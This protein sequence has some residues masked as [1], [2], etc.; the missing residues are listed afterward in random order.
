MG[1]RDVN[2]TLKT[3]IPD[4][5]MEIPMSNFRGKAIAIDASLYMFKSKSS[6]LK[7][8]LSITKDPLKAL[9]SK[10]LIESM[11]K[12]FYGFTYKICNFGITPVW[13]FDGKTH[14]AKLA[15]D[16]RK[17]IKTNKK[18][19]L[20]EERVRLEAMD[21]LER[22]VEID[23]FIKGVLS[24]LSFTK[25]EE[26]TLKNEIKELGLPCFDAPHDAEIFASAMSKRKLILGV[27]TTDT[28]TYAAG[29]L[30]TMTGFSQGYFKE[31]PKVEIVVPSIILEE[32]SITQEQFRDFCILH[33]CDF[34]QRIP[35]MGP[36]KILKKMDEYDWNL[37][38]FREAEPGLDWE[39]L[40]ID[41]CRAIFDGP[42]VSHIKISDL[43]IDRVKWSEK[44]RT[45]TFEMELPPDPE[46]V[47]VF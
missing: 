26:S 37:D 13:I 40:N 6:A 4:A 43:A 41:E 42:D 24:C 46:L 19:T 21:P 1:I 31:G 7:D 27:W 5:F 45:K 18:V 35:G 11:I 23:K 17:K 22:I 14:P 30:S 3:L 12:Q 16:R 8:V 47:E 33:E 15:T 29:S 28:D 25:E 9:D 20:E 34:N 44:M 39:I 36:A 2:K 38:K 10:L 32:L